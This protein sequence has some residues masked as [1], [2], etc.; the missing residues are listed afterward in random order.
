PL[1]SARA[2]PVCCVRRERT[3]RNAGG[4]HT[5]RGVGASSTS[6]PST[7]SKIAHCLKSGTN[8]GAT[9]TSVSAS[10]RSFG[11]CTVRPSEFHCHSI[12]RRQRSRQRLERPAFRSDAPAPLHGGAK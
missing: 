10:P 5:S 3:L 1:T 7:S 9:S 11:H 6:V 4:T 8:D 12:D 2:P